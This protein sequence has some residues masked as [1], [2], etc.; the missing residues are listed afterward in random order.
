VAI[1]HAT[2]DI[3][4]CLEDN[5]VD[6][7][8]KEYQQMEVNLAYTPENPI[9][10][11]SD[12]VGDNLNIQSTINNLLDGAA[13]I[14]YEWDLR[15]GK[16]MNNF[17]TTDQID[18]E[19][20][21]KV[22]AGKLRGTNIPSLSL[23]MNLPEEE[24]FSEGIAYL[25]V[26]LTVRGY[27]DGKVREGRTDVV[28]KVN[29]SKNQIKSFLAKNSND[30]ISLTF[31][32]EDIICQR[33]IEREDGTMESNLLYY[34][35]PVLQNQIIGLEVARDD[36]DNFA[37]SVNG[38]SLSCDQEMSTK[39][40]EDQGNVMFFPVLGN[41]G[42]IIDVKMKANNMTRDRSIELNRKFQIVEPYIKIVS[43][44]LETFW[45][46]LLGRYENTESEMID[47]FSEK[48]FYTYTDA[49][50]SLSA[51]FHPDYLARD[52]ENTAG[53]MANAGIQWKIDG[54]EIFDNNITELDFQSTKDEGEFY[55]I[56]IDAFYQIPE[57]IKN[58]LSKNWDISKISIQPQYLSDSVQA[59]V[60]SPDEFDYSE[61]PDENLINMKKTK[62]VLASLASNLP[63]QIGFILRVA[64]SMLV[65]IFV[66]GFSLS[67]I[68]DSR[69][70]NK[71]E[72]DYE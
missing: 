48:S 43:Q 31:E 16:D 10:D 58:A 40:S 11:P 15:I 34:V 17:E 45:P 28:I 7:R 36:M 8:A 30:G 62:K 32:N 60:I 21:E 14:Y 67:F 63:G 49:L 50:V 52:I 47:D 55:D 65:L 1:P 72:S 19:D 25:R 26:K 39:C 71:K 41:V 37:W 18:Q 54:E 12:S 29:S 68:G 20:L 3:N 22:Y 44:D 13:N 46:R 59:Q 69:V 33:N 27:V 38:V 51:E 4:D 35:C 6:P 24:Y 57:G 9:N 2:I 66:A 56:N 53:A 61:D 42:D 23:K 5:L 64:V 70:A